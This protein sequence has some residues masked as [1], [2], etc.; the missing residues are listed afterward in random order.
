MT[1]NP[2]LFTTALHLK[3][4]RKLIDQIDRVHQLRNGWLRD[5]ILNKDRIDLLITEIM[6]YVV[7]P[8]HL[9]LLQH[10]YRHTDFRG[11]LMLCW[12]GSGKS[13]VGTIARAIHMILK[14]PNVR[15]LLASK[16]GENA[17]SMLGE[18]K[19]HL[20]SA[21]MVEVFG[22]QVG[23]KWDTGEIIVA[24]RTSPAKESTI[25]TVGVE[26]AVVSKH[27]D[28]ILAD[29]LVDEKNAR[30]PP[31]REKV[32]TFY[33][34]S[35]KPCLEPD[36][37]LSVSGTRYHDLD[38]YGHLAANDM[39]AGR[40]IVIPALTGSDVDGWVSGWPAKFPVEFLLAMRAEMGSINFDTQ[41]QCDTAKMRGG[42]IIPYDLIEWVE[43]D[44]VPA[45]LPMYL[46]VDLAISKSVKA[47]RFC[48][49]AGAWDRVT[50]KIYAVDALIAQ[51]SFF[52]QREKIIEW[53]DKY[54]VVRAAVEAQ[55]YQ[56]GQVQELKRVR[57]D[58]PIVAVHQKWDKV[59]RAQRLS[60]RFENHLICWRKGGSMLGQV[61]DEVIAFPT[62]DHDDGLDGLD[63]MVGAVRT[64]IRKPPRAE[65]VGL[66]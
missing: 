23:E 16:S 5:Q 58:L 13:T 48:M 30:T 55:A 18:I 44:Q 12:R 46:G 21:R 50:D 47:D 66:I 4:R 1:A 33:Y 14:N 34:K 10:Q 37:S 62:G 45:G 43:P 52:Q 57:P 17:Q 15:I 2:V 64:K 32:R 63:L 53:C 9:R 60:A 25:T 59:T 8:H 42:G 7:E 27:Y 54:Q 6:G 22:A 36:G 56:E 65:E 41:Y 29:D 19:R 24:G 38:L 31:E 51:L 49:V 39:K 20:T 3:D 40:V 28:A 26:G 35:L 61:V 11:C